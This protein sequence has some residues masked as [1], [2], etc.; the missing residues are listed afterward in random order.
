[1]NNNFTLLLKKI[2]KKQLSRDEIVFKN[3]KDKWRYSIAYLI[4][5]IFGPLPLIC[6][7]WLLTA[8]K[9][10]IG[11]W[12][13]IWV[14][15]LI[16]I[17]VIGLPMAITTYLV[18]SKRVKNIEWS[19]LEQRNKYL[20]PL[21]LITLPLL[22][23]LNYFLINNTSFHLS[24]LLSIIVLS[25]LFSYRFFHFKISG[26]IVTA[27]ITVCAVSLYLGFHFLWLFLLI[28][29]LIWARLTLKVHTKAELVAGLLL[30]LAI[31]VGAIFLFGWPNIPS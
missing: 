7:V 16:F 11:F 25:V 3:P 14:Y 19:D 9:S 30:P 21:A 8:L 2:L 4:S 6:L 12:K 10:G 1:M 15:P 29:P 28:L 13:A 5:R 17:L 22:V 24:L 27:T 31:I 26:H 23:S 20:L 18:Y